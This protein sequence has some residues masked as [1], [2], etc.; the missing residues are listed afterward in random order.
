MALVD[1]R[2]LDKL[3]TSTKPPVNMT[4]RDIG[5]EMTNILDKTVTD[6]SEKVSLYNQALL[7]YN[8]MTK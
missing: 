8:D 4:L 1:P 3:R 7:R 6:M 2:L 5:A